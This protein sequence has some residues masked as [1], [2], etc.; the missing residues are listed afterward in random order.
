MYLN[1]KNRKMMME[2]TLPEKG[3]S[4]I[5]D[6]SEDYCT[7]NDEIS[8]TGTMTKWLHDKHESG[9]IKFK[10]AIYFPLVF[11]ILLNNT[12]QN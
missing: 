7:F 12:S 5:I 3:S 2:F 1:Y 4:V 8:T 11:T 6:L 10:Y 9:L